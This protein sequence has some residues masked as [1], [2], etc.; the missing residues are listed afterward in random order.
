MA[1]AENHL[2]AE[3]AGKQV[4][5]TV[6]EFSNRLFNFIRGKVNSD[7]DAEDILQDVWYQ[8]SNTSA[9][10][11][12]DQIS[13]WLFTVA[14]NKITDKYRRKSP[15]LIED[16]AFDEDDG[17]SV[18]NEILFSYDEEPEMVNLRNLFWEE[19]WVALEEI[20]ENQRLVF[21]QNELEDKTLQ[22]IA[23]ESGENIKTIISRKRYAVQHLRKRL[24]YLYDDLLKY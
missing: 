24:Q 22:E 13:G 15:D 12:I 1:E 18:F 9:T 6:K 14:R 19:L 23:N 2:M 3:S 10:E 21:V 11:T 16:F 8:Y 5:N 7:E 20:P 17:G 4:V